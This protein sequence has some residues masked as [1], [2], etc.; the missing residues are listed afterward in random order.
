MVLALLGALVIGISLGLLGSGGSILTL[1]VL[2]FILDRPEKIAV[3]ESLAIVGCI[4]FV[5]AIPY[6][7]R[8]NIHWKSVVCFGF[9]GMLGAYIGARC[10]YY[11]EEPVQLSLFAIVMLGASGM[12]FFGPPSFETLTPP[13]YSMMVT[14]LGG[15]IVGCITGIIGVGGGFLIVPALV[16]FSHLPMFFAIGT[17]LII[18]AM[19]SFTGFIEQQIA[20]NHLQM[21]VDWEIIGII[22]II[23]ILGSFAGSMIAKRISQIRL[24][25]IFGLSILVM[26]CYILFN[27]F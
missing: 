18:I 17:S 8:T 1:P 13:K 25:Q 7:I 6:A 20:L 16:L 4:A 23:G 2:I 10:S 19:N 15:F 12:M 14:I 11:I 27:Q 22:S 5:G 21:Q 9:P 26:G 24:R 3:A